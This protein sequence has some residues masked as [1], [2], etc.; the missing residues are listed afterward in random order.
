MDDHL[1][2]ACIGVDG[3]SGALRNCGVTYVHV[4]VTPNQSEILYI[5]LFTF[6]CG[7]CPGLSAWNSKHL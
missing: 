1:Q 4:P 3:L 5:K 6:F 2:T 7:D